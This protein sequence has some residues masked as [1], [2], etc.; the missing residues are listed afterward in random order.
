MKCRDID[1]LIPE[2]LAGTLSARKKNAFENHLEKCTVC[3]KSVKELTEIWNGVMRLPEFKPARSMKQRFQAM[4]GQE[5]ARFRM[6]RNKISGMQRPSVRIFRAQ[7]WMPLLQGAGILCVF[8][9]GLLA[10]RY[11]HTPESG[12]GAI[13]ALQSEVRSLREMMSLSLLSQTSASDRL[14]GIRL[15]LQISD[16][17]SLLINALIG[18]IRNDP[19][20]NVR[21]AAVDA[22]QQ[23][24]ISG[25]LA[26]PLLDA[27][28]QQESAMVQ[29]ALID[30][31]SVHT[32]RRT[33]TMLQ[34]LTG[35]SRL[36]PSVRRHAMK[37]LDEIT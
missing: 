27:V 9:L 3:A 4:L 2:Y 33:R 29:I 36:D 24:P 11:F 16:P 21:L 25:D 13:S 31:L 15:T 8:V 20:T 6:A 35:D 22:L 32:D 7:E 17:D 19:N 18:H 1:R 30:A 5:K 12:E 10:G 26:D 14:Q 28:T 34:N 23:I 37:R